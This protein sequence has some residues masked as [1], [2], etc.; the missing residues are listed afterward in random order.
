MARA[1]ALRGR[2]IVITGAS[3]GIGAA[4]AKRLA[5]MEG[6]QL[7][8]IARRQDALERVQAEVLALGGKASIYVADLTDE[9]A[10]DAACN[11]L[12]AAHARVDILVNSAGRSIRRSLRESF[13]RAHDFERT[14]RINYFGAMRMTLRLLP[15]MLTQGDGHIINISSVT[16]LMSTPRF[17]AYQAS[18]SA[19]DAFARSIQME[20]GAAGITATSLNYPLVN[21]PMIAPTAIYKH[22]DS[23]PV[24][25]AVDWVV[26]A[27]H[28]RRLRRT[29]GMAATAWLFTAL[30][31]KM[32]LR[33]LAAYYQRRHRKLQKQLESQQ[34]P[35]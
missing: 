31:P 10:L 16:A 8:L 15:R 27:M 34:E 9:Q 35:T 30:A 19:L 32:A 13:E 26:E 12:L 2:T 14:M 17:A 3:S 28:T 21:T 29:T 18:K 20:L 7:C 24:D 1:R 5:G 33:W 4:L 23:M 6:V 22:L 11:Q 25:A